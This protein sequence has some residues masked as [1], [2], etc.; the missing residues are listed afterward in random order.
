[1]T[2]S[3]DIEEAV[4]KTLA[5]SLVVAFIMILRAGIVFAHEGSWRERNRAR[6]K[7]ADATA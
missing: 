2:V 1:V 4:M 3:R 6:G 7:T 5:F